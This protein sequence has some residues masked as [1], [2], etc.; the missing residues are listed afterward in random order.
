MITERDGGIWVDVMTKPGS[1]ADK[2]EWDGENLNI[3]VRAKAVE[4]QANTALIALLSK[5]LRVPKSAVCIEKGESGR[6]K[7][8]SIR[9]MNKTLFLELL[10][11]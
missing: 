4:G 3:R 7:R 8:V 11:R 6:H 10:A 1:H 2:L 9:G 5:S